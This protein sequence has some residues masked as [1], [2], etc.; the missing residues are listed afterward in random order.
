[1]NEHIATIPSDA[2][3]AQMVT[4]SED[5]KRMW[6]DFLKRLDEVRQQL[7]AEHGPFED[8]VTVLART[9]KRDGDK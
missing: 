5:R 3:T 6:R 7:A 8:S 1:M 4:T 9:R 2:R